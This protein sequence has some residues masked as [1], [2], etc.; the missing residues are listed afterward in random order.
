M[1]V[2]LSWIEQWTSRIACLLV[3]RRVGIQM[4]FGWI[5][6]NIFGC[7]MCEFSHWTESSQCRTHHT[8][9][10]HSQC[11]LCLLWMQRFWIVPLPEIRC[12][13]RCAVVLLVYASYFWAVEACTQLTNMFMRCGTACEYHHITPHRVNTECSQTVLVPITFCILR[14]CA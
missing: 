13:A 6:M 5:F 3:A 14:G 11:W 8:L 1:C 7:D 2:N 9:Y 10:M 12:T 4:P